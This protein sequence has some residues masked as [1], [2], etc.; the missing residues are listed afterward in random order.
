LAKFILVKETL[1]ELVGI[2]IDK[3]QKD[4]N[5]PFRTSLKIVIYFKGCKWIRLALP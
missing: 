3:K 1:E 4:K 5:R 2:A